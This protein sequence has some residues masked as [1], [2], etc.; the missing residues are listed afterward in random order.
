LGTQ[1]PEEKTMGRKRLLTGERK[2]NEGSTKDRDR[3]SECKR[4]IISF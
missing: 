4:K 2:A 3:D 1:I